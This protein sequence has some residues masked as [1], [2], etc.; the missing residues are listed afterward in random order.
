ML[1][2]KGSPTWRTVVGGSRTYVDKVAKELSAVMTNTPVRALHRHPAGINI[3]DDAG[4]AVTRFDAAVVATHPDQA[5]RLLAEPTRAE[6]VVLGAFS[7]SRNPTVLH[8][9]T[10]VLPR[11]A[12]PRHP[13]TTACGRA[14][15]RPTACWS[16]MT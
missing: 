8:T 9:D 12:R 2:V 4:A 14:Q 16:A 1:S 13:G 3:H 7:Y 15:R 11:S 10:A 6:R 5:L